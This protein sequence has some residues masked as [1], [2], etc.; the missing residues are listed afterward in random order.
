MHSLAMLVGGNSLVLSKKE[1]NPNGPCFIK[2]VGRK[3]GLIDWLLTLI[4]VNTQTTLEVYANHIEYSYG[5]LS[6][7]VLEVIPLSK[8]SN[9]ICGNFR[10][11]IF[12]LLAFIAFIAAFVTSGLSLILTVIFLIFYF[13]R[14]SIMVGIIS[15]SGSTTTLAFKRSLIEGK[16]ITNE[17]AQNI[18]NIISNLVEKSSTP[19][20]KTDK[21][22]I[23]KNNNINNDDSC[24]NV[25]DNINNTDSCI[26]VDNNNDVNADVD[27]DET[28]SA[29]ECPICGS[30]ITKGNDCST[31]G[32]IPK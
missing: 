27:V 25:D 12:L 7:N 18:I 2:L 29:S 26:N 14:K 6:G 32:Y 1:I 24:I 13:L 19:I 15:N 17:E 31:C 5:S 4:G 30:H 23:E 21:N 3:A 28:K 10:P 11:V 9:L 22:Q 20:T 16:N 8:V